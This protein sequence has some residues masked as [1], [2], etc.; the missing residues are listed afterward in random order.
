MTVRGVKPTDGPKR[1]RGQAN[2]EW[3]EVEN[4]PFDGDVPPLPDGIDYPPQTIKWYEVVSRL[5]HAIL[6]DEG[7]WQEIHT[8]AMIHAALWSNTQ[9]PSTNRAVELRQREKNIGLTADQRRDLRIR[10][11]DPKPAISVTVGKQREID[12]GEPADAVITTL[13]PRQNALAEGFNY[14]K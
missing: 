13:R 7:E 12:A 14:G 4:T 5:P 6:W 1:F 9:N 11:V 2:T 8:T 10:Y 3:I